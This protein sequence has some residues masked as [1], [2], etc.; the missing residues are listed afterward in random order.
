[1]GIPRA[2]GPY[3]ISHEIG[4][5]GMGIVYLGHDPK[6]E[7][8]VAIKALPQELAEDPHRLE[9][10]EREAK[11]LA[12]L[13]HSNLAG[14][15]GL[16]EVD[17]A[18]YLVLEYVEGETLAQRLERGPLPLEEA[19]SIA[20]QIAE[21][22]EAAHAQR[23]MHRDLKP[24]NIKITPDG[25]VKVLDFGLAK[26]VSGEPF[27]GDPM[28]SPTLTAMA[29]QRGVI[30]GTAGY[31]SPEQ[32][33]GKPVDKRTD[34]W[35]FGCVLFE[36]LTGAGPFKGET[37]TDS[38]GAILHKDPE[39]E[40]LPAET[41]PRLLLLLRHCLARDPNRRLHDIADARIQLDDLLSGST[42][43]LSTAALPVELRRASR[44]VVLPWAL[45]AFLV[46][47]AAVAI[48][49]PRPAVSPP[50]EITRL[51]VTLPET[52][53]LD[54][55]GSLAISPDG[56]RLVYAGRSGNTINLFLRNLDRET[57]IRL[58]G[59]AGGQAPF[60]SPD[61]QWLGFLPEHD[62]TI[63]K[64][65]LRGGAPIT[66]CD[67]AWIGACW[68][69]DDTIIF[70]RST[71][72]L[73]R[74]P[75]AGGTPVKLTTLDAERGEFCHLWPH[76]LP[77]GEAL[78]FTV[79]TSSLKDAKVAILNLQTKE[80]RIL[81]AGGSDAR[82]LPTGH[83]VYA[84][85]NGL[86]AVGFDLDRLEITG[87]PVPIQED[88]LINPTSGSA[89]F[90][91]SGEGTA[92]FVPG[93]LTDR[94]LVWVDR[95]GTV[96]QATED[97]R[98]YGDPALSPDGQ[99]VAVMI[100][101]GTEID[102]WVLDLDRKTLKRLT[103][104]G[105]NSGPL[106]HPDGEQVVF[107]SMRDGPFDLYLIRADGSGEPQLLLS[108]PNDKFAT[109]WSPDGTVL[110]YDEDTPGSVG[111]IKLL[112]IEGDRTPQSFLETPFEESNARFSP[113]GRWIA[114]QSDESGRFQVY[115]RPATPGGREWQVSID[116]GTDPVWGPRGRELLYRNGDRM[117]AVAVSTKGEFQ[118]ETPV[119]LFE[120]RFEADYALDPG[121]QR[122]LM[123]QTGPG[124][125]TQIKVVLDWFE[126]VR[127]LVPTGR[128]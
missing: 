122:F 101:E 116:G 43:E 111:D 56:R 1:M 20:R 47:V 106:W 55:R 86:M 46:V 64:V 77:G 112:S 42:D 121:G 7:R 62:G 69:P 52:E 9:R 78:L 28:E 27:S 40:K 126:Q 95:D 105:Y 13:H 10:F 119:L 110:I 61:G 80:E 75:A 60:F 79:W 18:R 89:Q 5:G 97:L 38:I 35:S 81:L 108:G 113:D 107:S 21:A 34:I 120:G 41:P 74:V 109:C 3:E 48:W 65:S 36:M 22:V 117:M 123:V 63:R 76:M 94:C 26:A 16:E 24:A 92:A 54:G 128:D 23:V 25:L 30:L 32:A 102:V 68:C 66:I 49:W 4:R 14:V 88:V 58:D 90:C 96:Q 6:L 99:R 118:S 73:A 57:P 2:I 91:V 124:A 17:G 83:L 37:V 8:K 67:G 59:T 85:E 29:T 19:L 31:M 33:R 44:S 125:S 39:W 87:T 11:L 15:Y 98:A 82:Y 12:S 84:W 71:Y 115:V 104:G 93:S 70:T 103:H 50:G 45:V 100:T 114:Y 127:R 72:D 53:P 51:S